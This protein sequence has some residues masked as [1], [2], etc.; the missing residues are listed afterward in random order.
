MATRPPPSPT[1]STPSAIE[2]SSS[3]STTSNGRPKIHRNSFPFIPRQLSQSFKAAL[4]FP[5]LYSGPLFAAPSVSVSHTHIVSNSSSVGPLTPPLTIDSFP[6]PIPSDHP[7]TTNTATATSN[8]PSHSTTPMD[9]HNKLRMVVIAQQKQQQQP[10]IR[11]PPFAVGD[12]V[13]DMY[14][15]MFRITLDSKGTMAALCYLPTRFQKMIEFYHTEIPVAYRD[16]GLGDL[17]VTQGFRW[18]EAAKLLVIPTCPFVRRFL[19]HN[20]E[21]NRDCI[22]YSENEGLSKLMLPP[23][24]TEDASLQQQQHDGVE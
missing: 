9:T 11:K 24:A 3:S 20:N 6:T 23:A 22:V 15:C 16:L 13:H 7:T 8:P 17:L 2:S 18:A 19:E 10:W 12:V 5:R 14:C 21:P 4:P 1:S